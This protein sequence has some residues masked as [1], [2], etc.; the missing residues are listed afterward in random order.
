MTWRDTVDSF[1][2]EE[3]EAFYEQGLDKALDESLDP[4]GPDV[5]FD[6]AGELGTTASTRVLD[7]GSRIGKQMLELRDRFGCRVVGVEP[8]PA[9]LGRM[10]RTYPSETFDVVRAIGEA[11][12]FP[13]A[14]FDLVWIRDVLVH[15]ELLDP[16]FAEFRRVLKPGGAVL[17]FA[18]FATPLLEPREAKRLFM[19][20]AVACAPRGSRAV[21]GPRR[22]SRARGP[23]DVRASTASGVSSRRSRGRRR[24]R[25]SCSVSHA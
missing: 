4:R 15:F 19:R 1:Y 9:N 17:V 23:G 20:A 7:V 21:Q 3:I 25:V 14:A 22:W 13:D 18:V 16:A 24:R 10:R 8:A 11:L 6:I 5:L 12:P 2:S